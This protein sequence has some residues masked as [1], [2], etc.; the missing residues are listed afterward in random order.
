[1]TLLEIMALALAFI[2]GLFFM[3]GFV[4]IATE[5]YREF[6]AMEELDELNERKQKER[7]NKAQG[8]ML[9]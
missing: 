8:A 2:A 5:I 6:K 4:L 1:M 7:Q 3:G 9:K